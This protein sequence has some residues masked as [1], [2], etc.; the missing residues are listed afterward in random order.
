M[1]LCIEYLVLVRRKKYNMIL[2]VFYLLMVWEAAGKSGDPPSKADVVEQQVEELLA[3]MTLDEKIGQMIQVNS[4]GGQLSEALTLAIK[5]GEI[6]AILNEVRPEVIFEM[7]RI[8]REESRLGIPLLMGRD[9]IHGFNTVFPTNIGLAATFNPELVREGAAIAAREAANVG[10][11]WNFAPMV[12]VARDPRWGRMAES[13]GEDPYLVSAMGRA[14]VSGFQGNSL[15]EPYTLAACAKHFAAYGAAEG[16]RD[17]NTVSLSEIDLWNIYFPPFRTLVEEGVATFMTGFNELNGVPASGNSYLFREVLR[18][19]WGFEGFVVS[20]WNSIG[21][22]LEHGNVENTAAAAFQA[23]KAGVDME[24]AGSVYKDNLIDLM[25]S[26]KIAEAE[27][28]EAVRRILK[29]KFQLGL[30]S[31]AYH[32]KYEKL[33]DE[34]MEQHLESSRQS[35]LQSIVLLKND[36]NVLP[37]SGEVRKI[38]VIGPMSD[39][40]YEQLGTWIFDGDTTLT[41][42]PLQALK[43]RFGEDR[44]L[45]EKGLSTTRSRDQGRFGSAVNMVEKADVTVLILG[46]ESI[47]TGEAHSRAKLGLPGAQS[48]LIRVLSESGKPL[49]LVIMTSRPLVIEE[50]IKYCDAVLYAWHPGSMGGAAL[51]EVLLGQESPSGK[52]PVTFPRTE[53]QIPVY[54]SHKNTGRPYREDSFVQ[55][56]DIPVR[57]FQTS[58]GN[59]SH[60]IDYGAAPLFPF[61]YGLSY[62]RFEYSDLRLSSAGIPADSS[63]TVSFTLS[64]T[65]SFEAEEVA[66]LYIRDLVGSVTRPVKELKG[67]KRVRLTP[68]EQVTVTFTIG[69]EELGFFDKKGNY[70]IEPGEFQ[71][72][73]GGDSNGE[74]SDKFSIK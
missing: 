56:E 58:L 63:L 64:N 26:E 68:G 12:D 74:L 15:S 45:F 54:Y 33:S 14:M 43:D 37:L 62:T 24:M 36:N 9:V 8:A 73:V 67:F 61:G 66:Q 20:D 2:I 1:L 34:L 6:G 23:V 22:M 57:S 16:G 59:T 46:E 25:Q 19:K 51:A 71:V 27:I 72:W 4:P 69:R 11:N 10:L 47:L 40:R 3:R 13:F 60:Y 30:F 38:A 18:E 41:I 32:R 70:L 42:T 50:E 21:E 53:G 65:G 52:L 39:D 55:M 31:P 7:Q 17:Y 49:I 48:D 28:D 5:N 35:A 29:V 44:I